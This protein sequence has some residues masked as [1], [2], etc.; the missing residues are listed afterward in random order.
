MIDQ[1]VLRFADGSERAVYTQGYVAV[2][3]KEA[4]ATLRLIPVGARDRPRGHLSS[5]PEP[6]RDYWD[7]RNSLHPDEVE[8]FDDDENRTRSRPTARRV[9]RMWEAV[10]WMYL[11][12]WPRNRNVVWAVAS[13]FSYRKVAR[14]DGRSHSMIRYVWQG[15]CD[16]IAAALNAELVTSQSPVVLVSGSGRIAVCY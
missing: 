11:I 15:A 13:G 2:R 8:R 4:A 1:P 16:E 14:V 7:T 12:Q 6:V 9:S 3:L 5:M 10:M